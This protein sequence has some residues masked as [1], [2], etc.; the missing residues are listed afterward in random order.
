[1]CVWHR[2]K[3][4]DDIVSAGVHS[5]IMTLAKEKGH[6]INSILLFFFLR[7]TSQLFFFLMGNSIITYVNPSCQ[8]PALLNHRFSLFLSSSSS[9]MSHCNRV[10][11][12]RL[13]SSASTFQG[14]SRSLPKRSWVHRRRLFDTWRG[15]KRC[16]LYTH[17]LRGS[18]KQAVFR[19]SRSKPVTLFY[20]QCSI[21]TRHSQS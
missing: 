15:N 18:S 2:P 14:F 13:V 10:R 7:M 4:G 9:H 16:C 11:R 5:L 19:W 21:L 8:S 1:M 6:L 20:L 17:V 12:G 3:G